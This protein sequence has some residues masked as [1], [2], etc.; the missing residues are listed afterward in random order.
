MT[1]A[2]HLKK[3]DVIMVA[4]EAN[5]ED[6]KNDSTKLPTDIHVV[7]YHQDGQLKVDAVRSVKMSDVF[8]AYYDYGLK[9]IES[10]KNGYGSIRPNLYNAQQ[11][12][13]K[14]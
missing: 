2:A 4:E 7:S 12:K 1:K 6:I 10:I 14:D 5:I 13:D 8:D 3:Y 11:P 9:E